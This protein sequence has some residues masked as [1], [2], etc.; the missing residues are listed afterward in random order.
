[1]KHCANPTRRQSDSAR[2]RSACL[3]RTLSLIGVGLLTFGSSACG[4]PNTA[5]SAPSV[6]STSAA[7]STS[8][9]ANDSNARNAV[10]ILKKATNWYRDR[11]EQGHSYI[12]AKDSTDFQ[13]WWEQMNL[14][15]L[16]DEARKAYGDVTDL[17]QENE[18]APADDWD[19]IMDGK[20]EFPTAAKAWAQSHS[21]ADYTKAT[22]ALDHA[23]AVAE[24]ITPGI[25][26][27]REHGK[28]PMPA[29]AGPTMT[30]SAAALNAAADI[31]AKATAD[32]RAWFEKGAVMGPTSA[33]KDWYLAYT[34]PQQVQDM[35]DAF[36]KADANFTADDEP[37]SIDV[38]RDA[39]TAIPGDIETWYFS[40]KGQGEDPQLAAKVRGDFDKAAALA[41]DVR[42]GK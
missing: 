14:G 28:I 40:D 20:G 4:S 41:E 8:A 7:S 22:S 31:A 10:T 6:A 38:W 26:V 16:V 23:D 13:T 11:L 30:A 12:A 25:V 2:R 34:P 5:S 35:Q 3:T 19:E 36:S 15:L 17:Y 21:E 32:Y 27:P 18:P 29:S 9:A 24:T 39:A 33:Q 1:M 37:A 42:A